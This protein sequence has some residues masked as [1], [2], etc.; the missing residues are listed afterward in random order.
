MIYMNNK[1]EQI[2]VY[3]M[4]GTIV[5]LIVIF[6][7][8][9]YA[10][11]SAS[12]NK[13]STSIVEVKSGKMTISYAD[14][15]SS[16]LVSKDIQPSSK[17]IINKTFILTGTNTT[18]GLTM[19]YKIGIKY[20]SGFSNGQLHYYLKRMS[21]N[22]NITSNLIGISNQAIPG[23]TTDTGYTTGIFIKNNSESYLEL[24]N[25][26]FKA[27][28]SNQTITF[29][30]K[31]QFPDTGENQD[32]E[33]GATFAG[34][35]VVNY[36]DSKNAVNYIENLAKSEELRKQNNLEYDDTVD[37]NLRYTGISPNN[38]VS[39]NNELWRIIGDF[40]VYNSE[41]RKSVK[42]L[43]IIRNE[44]IGS[45]SWDSSSSNINDGKGINEWSQSKLMKELNSDFL[46]TV[47]V[48]GKN[49]WYNG[50]NNQM[51]GLYNYKNN[52]KNEFQ[53]MIAMVNWNLG[54][55]ARYDFSISSFYNNERG[56]IHIENVSDGV[57]RTDIWLGK[58]AL[59][60]PSDYGYAS[61][62]INCRKSM[63]STN[64]K[65]NNWLYVEGNHQWT[66]TPGIDK[67]NTVF[68]INAVGGINADVSTYALLIR[69]TLYLNPNVRILSGI[70]TLDNPYKLSL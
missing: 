35:I 26:E 10:F 50:Q 8:I 25:G 65:E 47:N 62:N 6:S 69:P 17:I 20:T 34:K 31:I 5:M 58:I 52:I 18:S 39:F 59:I 33:K 2:K 15:K 63:M 12:N 14:G 51:S 16:L 36:E 67:Q 70:G 24:A 1:E 7:G 22:S 53:Y 3:V 13:G 46:D 9:T 38:Y 4:I 21:A 32:S 48:L 37:N 43:K 55:G 57:E 44:S 19:P 60:Y 23:N 66:I 68:L 30:L 42:M 29:N 64:C 49:K 41:Y 27:N 45:F 54:A 40:S 61:T 11:F 56:T 28:T